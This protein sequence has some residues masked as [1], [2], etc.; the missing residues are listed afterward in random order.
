MKYLIFIYCFFLFGKDEIKQTFSQ[1]CT[2]FIKGQYCLNINEE[3]QEWKLELLPKNK[4][5]VFRRINS[6]SSEQFFF[7]ILDYN[8][9]PDR[10]RVYSLNNSG[11]ALNFKNCKMVQMC[12]EEER[13]HFTEIF[14]TDE[15]K[16]QWTGTICCPHN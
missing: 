12:G 16:V 13:E 1:D 3:E 5:F 6:N 14:F 7:G 15:G 4:G 8:D 10:V 2:L 9:R 11:E